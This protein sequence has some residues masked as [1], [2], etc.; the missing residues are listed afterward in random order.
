MLITRFAAVVSGSLSIG[1][2]FHHRLLHHS[3]IY[4][5]A[6]APLLLL[7]APLP[8]LLLL[9]SMPLLL[10][11]AAASASAAPAALLYFAWTA[12]SSCSCTHCAVSCVHV[13]A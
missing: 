8:L 4:S 7:V 12:L 13:R 5:V 11:A 6:V 3:V 9:L 10:T 1:K 2:G